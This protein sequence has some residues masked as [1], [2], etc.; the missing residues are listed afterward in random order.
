[1]SYAIPNPFFRHTTEGGGNY[2]K[3]DKLE[4]SGAQEEIL[5]DFHESEL[6]DVARYDTGMEENEIVLRD[7]TEGALLTGFC[8]D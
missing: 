4:D 2:R 7:V 6:G 3:F 5:V 1:M 8:E